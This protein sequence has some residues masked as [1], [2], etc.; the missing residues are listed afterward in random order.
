MA[1]ISSVL[2]A[3][4]SEEA[5]RRA[6]A[7]LFLVSLAF[8]CAAGFLFLHALATPAVILG[9]KN[10]GFELAT[11]VGPLTAVT[12]ALVRP[13]GRRSARDSRPVVR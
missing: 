11:T 13:A 9:A 6:D 10:A 3:R 5:R 12:A 4:L 8:F 2:A 1:A 7:R